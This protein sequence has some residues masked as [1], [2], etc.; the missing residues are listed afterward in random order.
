MSKVPYTISDIPYFV[1]LTVVGHTDFFTRIDYRE[2]IIKNLEFCQRNKGLEIYAYVLMTNHLH[3]IAKGKEAS[4]GETLRDF[5]S[6]TAKKMIAMM[7]ENP[8]ESRKE[9]LQSRFSFLSRIHAR[10]A[11]I[12]FWARDNY[13]EEIE[14]DW[15]FRQKEEYI[16]QNPVRA[17]F[18]ARPEDWYFSSASPDSPLAVCRV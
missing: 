12:Q 3:M 8:K 13:P 9:W 4:L 5:K 6:F 7:N 17:G 2:E 16:H 11:R 18:V 14:T 1:T 10:D 15:F